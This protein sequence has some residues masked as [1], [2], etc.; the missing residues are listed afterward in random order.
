MFNVNHGVNKYLRNNQD[1]APPQYF[2]KILSKNRH[3]TLNINTLR[4]F[5]F[6]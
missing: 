1:E 6:H 4:A 2:N 3:K 5:R